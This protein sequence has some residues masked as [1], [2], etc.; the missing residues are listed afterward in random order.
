MQENHLSMVATLTEFQTASETE[1]NVSTRTVYQDLCDMG[2]SS[3]A[4]TNKPSLEYRFL[5]LGPDM[6]QDN[7]PKPHV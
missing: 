4:V 6:N 3:Q 5:Q 1:N 7:V 2:V